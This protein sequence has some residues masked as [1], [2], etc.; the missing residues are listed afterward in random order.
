MK[1]IKCSN[2]IATWSIPYKYGDL[3]ERRVFKMAFILRPQR[4]LCKDLGT[5]MSGA[6]DPGKDLA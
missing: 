5:E 3:I 2:V 1:E 4:K 6:Q